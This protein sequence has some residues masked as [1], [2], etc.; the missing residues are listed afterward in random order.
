LL[1]FVYVHSL[2]ICFVGNL[3]RFFRARSSNKRQQQVVEEQV[4]SIKLDADGNTIYET[5]EEDQELDKDFPALN[6]YLHRP[7]VVEPP[8]CLMRELQDG[9]YSI[10]DLFMMHE[11]LD[12]KER[13]KRGE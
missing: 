5:E 10:D 6:Y 13:L 9:T 11:L 1:L 7:L 3:Q 2:F 12:L 4:T 8:L